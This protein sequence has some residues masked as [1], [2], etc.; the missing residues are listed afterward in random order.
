[1]FNIFVIFDTTQGIAA[2]AMR[3]SGQQKFGAILTFVAYFVL[4]IPLTLLLVFYYDFG[5]KGL[6]AGPSLACAFNTC[7][8]LAIYI[9]TDWPSLIERSKT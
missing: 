7:A 6:W 2:T 9:K 4:G 1:M 8:Y 5:I 3:A